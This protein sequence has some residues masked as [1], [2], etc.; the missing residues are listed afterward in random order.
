M[1]V[2]SAISKKTVYEAVLSVLAIA[3]LTSCTAVKKQ[4]G[5]SKQEQ[6]SAFE[7]V[8]K[9]RGISMQVRPNAR[10]WD[11]DYIRRNEIMADFRRMSKE[12]VPAIAGA[13]KDPDVQ[14][15]RNAT[16]VLDDMAWTVDIRAAIPSLIS[17]IEDPDNDVR[18]CAFIALGEIG[19][20]A[21][22]AV[23]ALTRMLKDTEPGPRA[24]S[25]IALGNIGAAAKTALPSLREA[26]NDPNDYVCKFSKQSIGLIEKACAQ[27]DQSN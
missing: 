12:A 14:M 13:L 2:S 15:R 16:L 4:E 25:A 17:A 23:P 3:I 21:K 27:N 20:D 11:L 8:E 7:T 1:N 18:L 19:P 9:M 10:P 24:T 22:E 5:T 6:V 26:L